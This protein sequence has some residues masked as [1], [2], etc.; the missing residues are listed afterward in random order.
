MVII[1][2]NRP[3]VVKVTAAT[4]QMVSQ[5]L[6]IQNAILVSAPQ[7]NALCVSMGVL[8]KYLMIG[9]AVKKKNVPHSAQ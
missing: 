7:I 4:N 6:I 1:R 2:M 9:V 8:G 5:H 3:I